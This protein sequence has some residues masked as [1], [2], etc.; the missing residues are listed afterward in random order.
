VDRFL[1][2]VAYLDGR[3][4]SAVFAR[5]YYTRSTLIAYDW[6][7]RRLRERWYVDSGWTP[8]TNPFNDAPHGRD[9]TDP[10][11]KTLTTQGAHSLSA[12]DVDGDGKQ[13]IVY[14]GATID[15]DG[16]L[17]YSS[18]AVLPPGS[19]A[20]GTLA[21]L[22]HGDAMHVTDV[23]P[24]RPGKEIFMVHEGGPSAPYGYALRDAAT[25]EVVFGGYTGVDTGRGMVGDIRPD[26]PGLETWG[27]SGTGLRTSDGQL[28]STTTPGTNMSIRWAGDLTTQIVDGALA[29]TPTIVDHLRGTVL[30]AEGTLT[31]NGTKGNPGLVADI[32]GDWREELLVR[33]A[34][35]GAIRIYLS[36]E[37]TPHKLATLMHDP[38]YRAEVARQ[39]TTYNQPSYPSYYFAADMDFAQSQRRTR[40]E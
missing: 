4:P 38:Q 8:M 2:G 31:N 17:L 23:D 12:A 28:I 3:H 33:T 32:F 37:P 18:F 14:G 21:R 40:P 9:G 39:Q 19:A 25:G 1:S 5:G 35:S 11:F 36:T 15:H 16:S 6:D 29:V 34:D 7:G 30:T 22:G 10:E 20:P 27:S 24:R 26:L 13:E